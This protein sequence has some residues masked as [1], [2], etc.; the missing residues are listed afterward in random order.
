[1]TFFITTILGVVLILW[2]QLGNKEI[3]ENI[4]V[5]GLI[6]LATSIIIYIIEVN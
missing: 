5:F 6:A 4:L 2:G 3:L 1:M